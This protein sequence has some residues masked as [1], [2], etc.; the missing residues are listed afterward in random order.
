MHLLWD[1]DM[2]GRV[3]HDEDFW[4]ADLAAL[5]TPGARQTATRGSVE[6]WATENLLA[7]KEA[8]KV[9]ETGERMKSGQRL[10]AALPSIKS[11]SSD[12][13]EQRCVRLVDPADVRYGRFPVLPSRIPSP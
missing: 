7:A 1:S 2:I 13:A 3:S 11:T 5:D 10:S 12:R 6:D 8:Y 9:P 4:L